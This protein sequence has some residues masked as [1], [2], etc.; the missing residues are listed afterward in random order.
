MDAADNQ[1]EVLD[2]T[3]AVVASLAGSKT[4]V[5]RGILKTIQGR[6]IR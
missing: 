2:R 5:A 1:V 4:L 6:L 3:G